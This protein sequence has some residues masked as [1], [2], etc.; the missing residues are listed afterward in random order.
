[1]FILLYFVVVEKFMTKTLQLGSRQ[2]TSEEII[3][4]LTSYQL[5]PQLL[6]ECVIDRAI[7]SIS[8]TF[9]ETIQA[10]L[11]FYQQWG[12]N[13]GTEQK[14]WQEQYSLSQQQLE[15]L[16][17][18]SLRIEKFKEATWGAQLECYFLKRKRQLDKVICSLI[19][20]QDKGIA[21]ELY[22]R[23]QEG[24][25]SFAELAKEYSQGSEAQTDGLM[26]PVELGELHPSLAS[27]LSA[28]QVGV[29]AQPVRLGE[30]WIVVR[31]ERKIPAQLDN[32][33]RH[34]LIQE[35]FSAWFQSQLQQLSS[36]EK[37]W[38]GATAAQLA[39]SADALAAVA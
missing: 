28:S 7:A 3:P 13:S 21:H 32:A 6:G 35:Q 1:L 26:G 12:L 22:F 2:L 24:E 14:A 8:C 33:M 18:R 31:V 34:R 16:V 15:A 25:Q 29:I 30:W 19:R 4:L 37:I 11:E 9:E 5:I 39:E 17:T 38:M 36:H 27:F 20:V 10:C 23:L